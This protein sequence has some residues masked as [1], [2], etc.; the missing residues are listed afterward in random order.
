MRQASRLTRLGGDA[1]FFALVAAG[2]MDLVVEGQALKAWDIEAAI[3]LIEGAGGVATDW[4]GRP[5]GDK[6]GQIILAGDP[7]VRDEAVRLLANT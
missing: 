2:T 4:S 1:Y 5:L 3:P 6:G 7:R